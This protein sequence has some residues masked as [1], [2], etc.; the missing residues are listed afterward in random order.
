M[1]RIIL[2]IAG[3]WSKAPDIKS[4]LDTRFAPADR[5]FAEDF[6]FVG[7]RADVLDDRDINAVLAHKSLLQ[8][9]VEFEGS[10][11]SW[12][13]KGARL[14]L[15]AVAAGAVGVFVETACKALSPPPS[16]G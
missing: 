12:A 9:A 13:E 10:A 6:V 15:D 7:R 8:A 16:K 5:E 3:P 2:T 11:R 14:A 4:D 1:G